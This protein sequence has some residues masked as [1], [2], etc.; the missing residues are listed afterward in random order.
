MAP[1]SFQ[2]NNGN[3]FNI[4]TVSPM[5]SNRHGTRGK[6]KK[7]GEGTNGLAS[8]ASSRATRSGVPKLTKE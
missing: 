8:T 2:S 6:G 7:Q 3:D 4:D 5:R 1:H